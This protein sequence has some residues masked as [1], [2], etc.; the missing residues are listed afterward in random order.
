MGDEDATFA[1]GGFMFRASDDGEWENLGYIGEDG[2][3][4]DSD[5]VEVWQ[6]KLAELNQTVTIAL[7]PQWWSLNRL[8][9]LVTGRYR[10]TVRSLRRWNKGHRRNRRH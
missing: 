4:I 7:N 3:T 9:K 6:G 1:S 2:I 5:D 8:Y 10:Y